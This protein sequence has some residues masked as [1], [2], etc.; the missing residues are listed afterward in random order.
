MNKYSRRT[1][2][3]T[4]FSSRKNSMKKRRTLKTAV[5]VIFTLLACSLLLTG[6]NTETVKKQNTAVIFDLNGI[7]N[8]G[9]TGTTLRSCAI[10]A[11]ENFASQYASALPTAEEK[12]ADLMKQYDAID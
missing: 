8:F 11:K 9:N 5:A 10:G 3:I 6:C 12:L 2:L 1:K 4:S 7:H